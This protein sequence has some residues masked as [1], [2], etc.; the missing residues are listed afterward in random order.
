MLMAVPC[1]PL[2]SVLK[3]LSELPG[4]PADY[5]VGTT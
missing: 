2:R 3:A 1:S 4:L 5:R